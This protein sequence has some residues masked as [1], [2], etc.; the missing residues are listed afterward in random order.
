[1]I[2][3]RGHPNSCR[4]MSKFSKDQ[5]TVSRKYGTQVAGGRA[6][7]AGESPYFTRL[8]ESRRTATILL[9]QAP[10]LIV[11]DVFL[12]IRALSCLCIF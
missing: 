4:C 9:W 8:L 2:I 11:K 6:R 12:S 3:P 7:F 5:A 10:S 1:M